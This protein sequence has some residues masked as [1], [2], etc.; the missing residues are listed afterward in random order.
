LARFATVRRAFESRS[1][2]ELA[3]LYEEL[4]SDPARAKQASDALSRMD[5][6]LSVTNEL[7]LRGASSLLP[8]FAGLGRA[9]LR[10]QAEHEIGKAA[11]KLLS[12]H[13]AGAPFPMKLG[14]DMLD[15]FTGKPIVYRPTATGF[16]I[17][18][19]GLDFKDNHGTFYSEAGKEDGRDIGWRFPEGRQPALPQPMLH[20]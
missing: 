15:P 2:H 1:I 9:L 5:E 18:S 10:W 16:V 4:P 11:I 17:Y 6:R 8:L 20:P 12:Q 3:T 14:F 7:S 13:R 19:V